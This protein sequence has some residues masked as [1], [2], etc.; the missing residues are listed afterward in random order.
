MNSAQIIALTGTVS[1]AFLA[2]LIGVLLNNARL[3]DVKE[4]LRA[5][6]NAVRAEVKAS[7]AELRHDIGAQI[8]E[9]KLIIERNHSET[10]ARFAE[11]EQRLGRLEAERRVIQ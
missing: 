11:I 1:V 4:A 6:I 7:Q 5:E 9:L 8:A 10:L 3:G 2:V